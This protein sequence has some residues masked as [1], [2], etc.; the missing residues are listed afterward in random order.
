[1]GNPPVDLD[2]PAAKGLAGFLP[3]E[4]GDTVSFVL[5]LNGPD[6]AAPA[7]FTPYWTALGERLASYPDGPDPASV[8]PR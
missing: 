7:N 3:T 5:L 2:P 1:L 8:G 4:R 6:V